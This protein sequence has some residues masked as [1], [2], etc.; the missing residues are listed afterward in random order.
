MLKEGKRGQQGGG[1]EMKR[2]FQWSSVRAPVTHLNLSTLNCA[3]MLSC[4]TYNIL[5]H[6]YYGVNDPFCTPLTHTFGAV[7]SAF[8]NTLH[9]S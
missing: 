6:V 5:L 2:D 3:I 1:E 4:T 9:I 8:F 7:P